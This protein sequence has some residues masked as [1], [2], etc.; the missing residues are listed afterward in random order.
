MGR[1]DLLAAAK[2]V[3][4]KVPATAGRPYY[5]PGWGRWIVPLGP[6]LFRTATRTEILAAKARALAAESRIGRQTH[7]DRRQ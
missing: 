6:G 3:A 1:K 2:A 5:S 7:S 4:G